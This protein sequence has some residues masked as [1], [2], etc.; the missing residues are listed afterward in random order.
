ML[1]KEEDDEIVLQ[2]V[3]AIYH[4]LL[5]AQ[6][7][8]VLLGQSVLVERLIDLL[9]DRNANIRN[10]ADACLVLI[11]VPCTNLSLTPQDT[12]AEWGSKLA[13]QKF[14]W[15]NTEWMDRV[16]SQEEPQGTLGKQSSRKTTQLFGEDDEEYRKTRFVGSSNAMFLD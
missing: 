16:A 6:S 3:Y 2:C 4:F 13:G 10:L 15:Y 7:R 11:A 12:D 5:C 1:A 8:S 14:T 9:Y